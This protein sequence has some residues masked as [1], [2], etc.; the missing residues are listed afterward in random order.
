MKERTELPGVYRRA[1]YIIQ[2]NGHH[3]G[4]YVPDPFSRVL[5]TPRSARP[6]SAAAALYCAADPQGRMVESPLARAAIRYAAGLV[7]VDGEGP[8]DPARDTDC[9]IHLAAW[10]DAPG[11]TGGEVIRLLLSAAESVAGLVLVPTQ[12]QIV[13]GREQVA[14]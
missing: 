7:L 4:D 6:M 13:L 3:Q 9:E 1:A 2:M 12:A 8:W 5:T 10:G 14:A 11:R